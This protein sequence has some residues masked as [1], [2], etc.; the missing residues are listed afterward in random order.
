M[1]GG[2]LRMGRNKIVA[3]QFEV[4][5]LAQKGCD[6]LTGAAGGTFQAVSMP[7]R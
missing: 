5:F 1:K 3:S 4:G 6:P 7:M 2:K